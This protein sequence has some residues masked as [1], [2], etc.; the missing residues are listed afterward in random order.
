MKNIVL[1]GFMGT[2]KTMVGKL[3]ATQLKR[4]RLCLDDMIEWKVGKPIAKIFQEDGEKF[5]REIESEIVKAASH[6][7]N[8]VIDAGGGVVI[9]MNNIKRL[10]ERGIVICLIAR[11]EV[12]YERTKGSIHRPLL[13]TPDPVSNIRELLSKRE[14]YY[15]CADYT[16]DTSDISPEEIV[17]KILNIMDIEK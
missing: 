8:V 2:G 6:D 14:E 5:F 17:S 13:N 16:V 1:V 10:K 9:D 3:L 7:K 12:I 11:P 15:R 4:Q